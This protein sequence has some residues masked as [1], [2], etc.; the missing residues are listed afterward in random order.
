MKKLSK[1]LLIAFAMMIMSLPVAAAAESYAEW[2]S[3]EDWPLMDDGSYIGTAYSGPTYGTAFDYYES[4]LIHYALDKNTG[5]VIYYDDYGT[6]VDENFDTI[7]A[8]NNWEDIDINVNLPARTP[9][10]E[11]LDL[12]NSVVYYAWADD[13]G[14]L[15]YSVAAGSN[16][17]HIDN[18]KVIHDSNFEVMTYDESVQIT[19]MMDTASMNGES[20]AYDPYTLRQSLITADIPSPGP[21]GGSMS[22]VIGAV[23]VVLIVACGAYFMRGRKKQTATAGA[24]NMENN[25]D[26]YQQQNTDARTNTERAAE[27]A[28]KAANVA[29]DM[30]AKAA[31]AAKT[32]AFMAK[33]KANAFS[34]AYKEAQERQRAASKTVC[35][36]CGAQNDAGSKFCQNCGTKL[37]GE[38]NSNA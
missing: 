12:V 11:R 23:V 34:K 32:T 35:P 9:V 14:N 13:S 10:I 19:N 36:N 20:V 7:T 30:A 24:E 17:I 37:N 28:A 29:N 25:N 4:Y 2:T 33:E 5:A 15:W 26:Q 27:A 8:P 3:T 1:I 31:D 22:I 38:E 16:I 21:N 6:F 18:E